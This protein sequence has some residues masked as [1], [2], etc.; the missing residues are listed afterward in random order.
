MFI[1]IRLYKR[2]DMDII[3]LIDA[4]YDVKRMME[5]SIV[6]FANGKAIAFVMD[7]IIKFK[8]AEKQTIHFRANIPDTD[9]RA[10]ALMKAVNKGHRNSFCKALF[11]N[12][13]AQQNLSGYFGEEWCYQLLNTD[14]YNKGIDVMR[15]IIPLDEFHRDSITRTI[16]GST[17][18]HTFDKATKSVKDMKKRGPFTS[19][20]V[21]PMPPDATPQAKPQENIRKPKP[22]VENT[23]ENTE[24]TKEKVQAGEGIRLVSVPQNTEQ[25]PTDLRASE[26]ATGQGVEGQGTAQALQDRAADEPDEPNNEVAGGAAAADEAGSKS[27]LE[28]FEA[29]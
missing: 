23:V 2:F 29:L 24:E 1:D 10:V 22:F 7:K 21:A 13:F 6:S 12:A 11:R 5:V 18:T 9:T 16:E 3:S 4:G 25:R 15:N 8:I 17:I 19:L 20:N 14:Y 26:Q 28:A 27:F